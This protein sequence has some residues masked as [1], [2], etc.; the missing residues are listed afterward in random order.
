[1]SQHKRFLT[2]VKNL[3]QDYAPYGSTEREGFDCSCGCKHY[4]PVH[5]DST[6]DASMDW[7]VCT[8]AASHRS[9]MLTFEHQG[10]NKFEKDGV[11]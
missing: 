5:D 3:P 10:C 4:V 1:M 9:G 8:N 11:S 2:V 6:R 7:G